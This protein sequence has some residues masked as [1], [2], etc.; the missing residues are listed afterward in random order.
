MDELCDIHWLQD[1]KALRRFGWV[2][3]AGM[4]E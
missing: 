4:E 3:R 1:M 2:W